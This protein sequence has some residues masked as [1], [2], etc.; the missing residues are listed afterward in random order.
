V[1]DRYRRLAERLRSQLTDLDREVQRALKSW[2]ALDSA[3]DPEPYVDS[4][5]LNLHGFYSGL[6]RLF[7]LIAVQVDGEKPASETWHRDL[8]DRMAQPVADARPAV[9]QPDS[10]AAL[11]DFRKFRHIVRNVYT[12]NLEP[13]RMGHL[14]R[15]LPDLWQQVRADLLAF[16]EL[17][18]TLSADE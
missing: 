15:T 16:A 13:A 5:A 18:E 3:S 9:L 2:A 10:A 1:I 12:A 4:V 11:D 17:L 7:E 8:L 14:L 6:E